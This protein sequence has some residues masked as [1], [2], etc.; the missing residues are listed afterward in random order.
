[1]AAR[2][3]LQL[4]AP[5]LGMSGSGRST[6]SMTTQGISARAK[7][8][9]CAGV[10]PDVTM[11][12]PARPAPARCSAHRSGSGASG[13]ADTTAS[14]SEV[15]TPRMISTAHSLSSAGKTRSTT[16][17]RCPGGR[18]RARSPCCSSTSLDAR[19]GGRRDVRPVVDD[20]R[21]G[22]QRDARRGGHAAQRGSPC[23]TMPP[24]VVSVPAPAQP[25]DPHTLSRNSFSVRADA[26]SVAAAAVPTG[27]AGLVARYD[28]ITPI[29]PVMFSRTSSGCYRNSSKLSSRTSGPY[30]PTDH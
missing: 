17:Q 14:S 1:M 20:L 26:A 29:D 22:G 16:A 11:I 21:D 6:G 3:P 18:S 19:A 8:S 30:D 23:C 7:A 2:P 28:P 24:P 25:V 13:S 10:S 12:A 5:T 27:A 4:V 9:R 15:A